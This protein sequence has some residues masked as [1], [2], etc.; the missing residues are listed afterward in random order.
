M[1]K[2]RG[3]ASVG[4]C[5][6]FNPGSYPGRMNAPKAD[7]LFSRASCLTGRLIRTATR[8]RTTHTHS[9]AHAH[10]FARTLADGILLDLWRGLCIERVL[11]PSP[12]GGRAGRRG[13][14]VERRQ[15]QLLKTDERLELL[16]LPRSGGLAGG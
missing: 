5:H 14:A 6:P 11:R 16:G 1:R 4:C 2:G 13:H 8:T 15:R 10:S 3:G 9:C 7:A 12:P